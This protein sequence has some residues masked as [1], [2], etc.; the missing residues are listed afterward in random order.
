MNINK[1]M[2]ECFSQTLI[3]PDSYMLIRIFIAKHVL[4]SK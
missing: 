2:L 4:Y 1:L 3:E